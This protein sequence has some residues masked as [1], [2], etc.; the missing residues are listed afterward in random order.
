MSLFRRGPQEY[1]SESGKVK[2]EKQPVKDVLSSQLA[3]WA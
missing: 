1:Q 2:Q 3:L